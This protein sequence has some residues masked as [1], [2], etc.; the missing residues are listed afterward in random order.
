[1]TS[2]TDLSTPFKALE[3][4]LQDALAV[5]FRRLGAK[6]MG[7]SV[8][9][10]IAMVSVGFDDDTVIIYRGSAHGLLKAALEARD[11]EHL[12]RLGDFSGFGP[13]HGSTA[14]KQNLRAAASS[15]EMSAFVTQARE[16][17][18]GHSNPHVL[19]AL[20]AARATLAQRAQQHWDRKAD[21]GTLEQS[22]RPLRAA[23]AAAVDTYRFTASYTQF[24][25]TLKLCERQ[26]ES[27]SPILKKCEDALKGAKRARRL[28]NKAQSELQRSAEMERSIFEP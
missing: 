11:L 15:L 4:A 26:I 12:S 20:A 16:N 10:P 6:R 23:L 9:F 5:E 24:P 19:M 13:F 7:P 3:R 18:G 8:A 28:A 25:K 21:I 17:R 27:L 1:M 14:I 22:V 2:A